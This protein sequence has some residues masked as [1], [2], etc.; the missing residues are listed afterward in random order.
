MIRESN[1]ATA[2]MVQSNDFRGRPGR[3]G[4]DSPRGTHKWF[5][6]PVV[7][8]VK[9][10]AVPIEQ[11]GEELS[12]VVV[13]RLLEEVQPPHVAQVGGHLFCYKTT[14]RQMRE[15]WN[16]NETFSNAGKKETSWFHSPGK[17]SQSTSIGVARLVSPIFWYRSFKVSA[18][19]KKY[20]YYTQIFY[21]SCVW[22][23]WVSL[24]IKG[25][26]G[27]LSC[28]HANPFVSFW[29]LESPL[30]RWTGALWG[31]K[32][33]LSVMALCHNNYA[34]SFGNDLEKDL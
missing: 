11:I 34:K 6:D 4:E 26:S 28:T 21:S 24:I 13:I 2:A 22:S 27:Y 9:D 19:R 14:W 3:G 32:P 23:K 18:W 1:E 7:L 15:N 30:R 12:Q 20:K 17:L 25:F 33:A 16:S 8:V 10:V 5:A 31:W 29:I